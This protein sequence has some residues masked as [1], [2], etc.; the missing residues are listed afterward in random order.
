MDPDGMDYVCPTCGNDLDVLDAARGPCRECRE[1]ARI[2]ELEKDQKRLDWL[3]EGDHVYVLNNSVHSSDGS[4]AFHVFGGL[5]RSEQVC[6]NA[7]LR[8]AIDAAMEAE[9]GEG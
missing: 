1:S 3:N 8:A 5:G 6:S 2:A 9:K 7:E 4:R